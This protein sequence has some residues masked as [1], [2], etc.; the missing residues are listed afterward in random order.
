MISF[1][2]GNFGIP[3]AGFDEGDVG[4]KLESRFLRNGCVGR[5]VNADGILVFFFVDYEIAGET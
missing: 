2:D 5:Q 3:F 1:V 4:S